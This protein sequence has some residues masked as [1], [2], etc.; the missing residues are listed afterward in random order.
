M[1][2]Y[3]DEEVEYWL[4]MRGP[5]WKVKRAE[6]GDYFVFLSPDDREMQVLSKEEFKSLVVL[7]CAAP[8]GTVPSP[9]I[10]SS[11]WEDD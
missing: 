4:P 2:D 6:S 1:T 10:L 3:T 7:N 5:A 9:V 8:V 11:I